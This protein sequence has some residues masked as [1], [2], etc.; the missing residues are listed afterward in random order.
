MTDILDKIEAY[1]RT[2]ISEAKVRMPLATLERNV[3]DHDPG[4]PRPSSLRRIAGDGP[5]RML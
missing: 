1:K 2:E 5:G 4:Y 3:R